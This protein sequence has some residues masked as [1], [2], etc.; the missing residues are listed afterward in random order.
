MV[1]ILEKWF[2]HLYLLPNF[3]SNLAILIAASMP[4]FIMFSNISL[5]MQSSSVI[6]SSNINL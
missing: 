3:F 6:T 4:Y 1:R 5:G 2:H